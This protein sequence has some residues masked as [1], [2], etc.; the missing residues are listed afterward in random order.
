MVVLKVLKMVARREFYSAVWMG[1]L[2]VA[3]RVE[4]M[5]CQLVL[6]TVDKKAEM[7]D[8]HSVA[9]LVRL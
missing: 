4:Q 8:L 3:M 6:E 7:K 2:W 5:V 1:K 9:Y